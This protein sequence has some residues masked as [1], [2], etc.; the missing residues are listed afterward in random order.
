VNIEETMN[1]RWRMEVVDVSNFLQLE[2]EVNNGGTSSEDGDTE[3][4]SGMSIFVGHKTRSQLHFWR[5]H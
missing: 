3:V 2:A 1:K 5:F 4:V